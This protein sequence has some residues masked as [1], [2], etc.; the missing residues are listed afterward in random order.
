MG[1]CRSSSLSGWARTSARSGACPCWILKE[2]AAAQVMFI[3]FAV[4]TALWSVLVFQAAPNSHRIH[5]L[6]IVLCV[7]KTLTLLS[8]AGMYHIIRVQGQP[9]GWGIA[10]YLFTFI[11][12]VLFFTVRP[13]PPYHPCAACPC[14]RVRPATRLRVTPAPAAPRPMAIQGVAGSNVYPL[15]HAVFGDIWRAV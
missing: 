6:M 12:G 2:H 10:F 15:R 1:V 3:S 11:R 5:Y 9:G 7:F 4:V 8:Q 14:R 13:P